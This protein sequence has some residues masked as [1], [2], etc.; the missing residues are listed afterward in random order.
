MVLLL[1]SFELKFL[2]ALHLAN[3]FARFAGGLF[4]STLVLVPW[5]SSLQMMHKWTAILCL[6]AH[7]AENDG[8]RIA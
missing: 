3:G 6:L 4:D 1:L 5:N 8:C 7:R 2:V